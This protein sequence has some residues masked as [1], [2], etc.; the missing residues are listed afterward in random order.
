[1]EQLSLSS[2]SLRRFLALAPVR[3]RR[4]LT[5]AARAARTL[6]RDRR[7]WHVN[8]T[9]AGGGVAEMLQTLLAYERDAGIDVRWLVIAGEPRFFDL[10]KQLH[11]LLHGRNGRGDFPSSDGAALYGEVMR[12]NVAHLRGLVRPND[13]VVLHDP[14]TAGLAP[15]LRQLGAR[16]VWRCHV[17]FDGANGASRRGWAFLR[18]YLDHADAYVFSRRAYVPPWL[19]AARSFVITPAIDPLSPKNAPLGRA[20]VRG[21]LR[22]IGLL[23]GNGTARE[24]GRLDG[25]ARWVE[26]RAAIVQTA[27]LPG[28]WVPTAVQVSRWDPLKDMSGVMR[29]FAE[30]AHRLP[31]VHLVLAGADVRGVADDPEGARVYEACVARWRAL[32]PAVRDRVHLVS[33]PM[34]D[35]EENA[36]MVNALQRH[37][38]VIV[39]KSLREGFGLTVTEG[40]WK[41]RAILASAVGGI[42]DQIVHGVHGL[43][44]EPRDLQGFGRALER[45]MREP[46]LV[47]RIGRNARRRARAQFLGHRQLLQFTRIL[48]ELG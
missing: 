25:G 3:E 7:V 22:H 5:R 14:Q 23:D 18:P 47:Q 11:H 40:M 21:I 12:R 33:L 19:P 13:I 17:G 20:A 32:P 1:M 15:A 2:R 41:G 45:L 39:Q 26:R 24:A 36:L 35:V 29:G 9:G 28:W 16:V 34:D 43:L 8:S 42:R 4:E 38:T 6:L 46:A 30:R 10:T 44:V 48:Q 37:A 27:P 31:G